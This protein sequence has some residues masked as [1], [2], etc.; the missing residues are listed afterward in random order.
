MTAAFVD[1]SYLLAPIL[2]ERRRL[3]RILAAEASLGGIERVTSYGVLSR[4][5]DRG[6]RFRRDAAA[7]I[8]SIVADTALF[9]VVA[10]TRERFDRGLALYADRLDQRYSLEDCASMAIMEEM[11]IEV[12]LTFDSDFHGEGRFTVLPAAIGVEAP[13]G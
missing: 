4:V 8:Q 10:M 11:G 7:Y 5:S 6:P 12:V 3:E 13:P 1:A 2:N 9:T